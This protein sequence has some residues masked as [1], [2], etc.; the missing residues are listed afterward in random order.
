MQ[1]LQDKA[2]TELERAE[3][4][5]ALQLVGASA[6]YAHQ[7]SPTGDVAGAVSPRGPRAGVEMTSNA[8]E[9][10]GG[11]AFGQP[12][13]LED[14]L[15]EELRLSIL[16]E[17]QE[18]DA[19]FSVR[20]AELTESFGDVATV[21]A[22][23]GW[24]DEQHAWFV[25]LLKEYSLHELAPALKALGS[26]ARALALQRMR[27][28]RPSISREELVEHEAMYRA[29]KS[30]SAQVKALRIMWQQEREALD[31]YAEASLDEAAGVYRLNSE[32]AANRLA[33]DR[34]RLQ[35]T[36]Q[37]LEWK[38]QR[39][40]ARAAEDAEAAEHQKE[41][42]AWCAKE[43]AR[44]YRERLALKAQIKEFQRMQQQR[45]QEEEDAKVYDYFVCS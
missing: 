19:S 12:P 23:C 31:R 29:R 3:R 34:V 11:P 6:Q 13:G 40:E 16:V 41:R 22:G 32:A 9:E 25:S 45:Q 43:D 10:L 35:L 15:D 26:S 5:L 39:L 42:A 14:C 44:R 24:D 2:R 7:P 1:E 20:L 17:Y 21:G 4:G 30:F 18:L 28:E 8:I 33:L 36:E 38:R 37:V 27:M